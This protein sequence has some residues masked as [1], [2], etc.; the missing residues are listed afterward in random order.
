MQYFW[1]WSFYIKQDYF[2]SLIYLY[3]CECLILSCFCRIIL[4]LLFPIPDVDT[5]QPDEKSIITYVSSLHEVF[6]EPPPIHPLY[7]AQAQERV[8]EYR[9]LA[10]SLHMWIREKYSLMQERS[11]PQTLIEMKK[12][13]AESTRFRTEEIPP[14]QRDKNYLSQMYHEL[15]KYFTAVGENDVEPELRIDNIERNWQ[16]LMVAYQERDRHI[17]EEVTRLEALQRLAEKVCGRK[18]PLILLNA[19]TC[20]FL[21]NFSSHRTAL[22]FWYKFNN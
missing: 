12:L 14:R 10:S 21:D 2:P 4:H 13:A 5:H 22:V 7:D 1:A 19:C 20:I 17:K 11:F 16:R 3:I 9:K 6:P 8:Q 18:F 15:E